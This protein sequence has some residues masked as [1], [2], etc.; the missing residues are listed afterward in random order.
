M[1]LNLTW[2]LGDRWPPSAGG[3]PLG[4]GGCCEVPGILGPSD[5]TSC[6]RVDGGVPCPMYT[7]EPGAAVSGVASPRLLGL[8]AWSGA[9][10][11]EV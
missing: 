5:G 4:L 1:F 2:S 3:H 7:C 9:S 11:P 10:G 6:G 8:A